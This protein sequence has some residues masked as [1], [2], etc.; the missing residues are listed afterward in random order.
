[1][2]RVI[3][4]Y[5]SPIVREGIVHTLRKDPTIQVVGE[6]NTGRDA[7]NLIM[8]QAFDVVLLGINLPDVNG[9]KFSN[10]PIASS[11]A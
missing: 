7:E 1:M 4:V 10:M 9:L 3:V 5:N 11:L 8:Q 2:T 6:A